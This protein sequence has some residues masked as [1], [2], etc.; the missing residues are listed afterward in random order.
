MLKSPTLDS[1]VENLL[2]HE[3]HSSW[4]IIGQRKDYER[5]KMFVGRK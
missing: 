3:K 1:E 2:T 4:R 5:F